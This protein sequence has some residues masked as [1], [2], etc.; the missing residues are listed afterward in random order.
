MNTFLHRLFVNV[1]L[2]TII[3]D[4][5]KDRSFNVVL[6]FLKDLA[7]EEVEN[8]LA[9][10]GLGHVAQIIVV[11]VPEKALHTRRIND[12]LFPDFGEIDEKLDAAFP[13]Q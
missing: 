12:E 10:L 1:A 6:D 2:I 3:V 9:D 11:E 13:K 5:L 4:L 7:F 8:L